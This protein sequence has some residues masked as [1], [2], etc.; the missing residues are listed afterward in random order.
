M[1]KVNNTEIAREANHVIVH[2][3]ES[4]ESQVIIRRSEIQVGLVIVQSRES[5]ASQVATLQNET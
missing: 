1:W 3:S 2:R 4:S 5:E